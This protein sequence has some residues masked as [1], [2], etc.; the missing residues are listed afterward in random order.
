[1]KSI[2]ELLAVPGTAAAKFCNRRHTHT[3]THTASGPCSPHRQVGKKT[4]VHL[5]GFMSRSMAHQV[6]KASLFDRA[7]EDSCLGR[8]RACFI[9]EVQLSHHN[10]SCKARCRCAHAGSLWHGFVGPSCLAR[11][12][13]SILNMP[14]SALGLQHCV[15]QYKLLHASW[16]MSG[17]FCKY[18]IPHSCRP[19]CWL[20]GWSASCLRPRLLCPS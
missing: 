13:K 6:L 10:M 4:A 14:Q 12:Y 20:S 17:M 16:R 8:S 1:M 19:G 15:P 7:A 9:H 18:S 11:Y 5:S 3:S 2:S